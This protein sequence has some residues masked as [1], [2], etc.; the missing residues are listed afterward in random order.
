[1]QKIDCFSHILPAAYLQALFEKTPDRSA[2]GAYYDKKCPG[3]RDLELRFRIMDRYN[4]YSQILCIAE[5]TVETVANPNLAAELAKIAND[6]M[7]ELV[8]K[9][10]DRFLAAIR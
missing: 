6:S 2:A 7:A 10:P 1:M 9:Y 4:G 8:A 5:P 3:V